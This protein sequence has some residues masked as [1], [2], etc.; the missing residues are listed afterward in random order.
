MAENAA[1]W[2]DGA[3][4]RWTVFHFSQA[5]PVG[6]G[7]DDVGALLRRVADSIDALG[8]IEVQELVMHTEVTA[9][10]A[11]HSISVYYQRDD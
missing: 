2:R 4:D 7:Q 10:G 5:N 11:W 3:R 6:P 9:D 1:A 8:D